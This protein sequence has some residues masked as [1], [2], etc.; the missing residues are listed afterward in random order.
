MLQFENFLTGPQI[1]EV[2]RRNLDGLAI[3]DD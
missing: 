3:G 1:R 2:A